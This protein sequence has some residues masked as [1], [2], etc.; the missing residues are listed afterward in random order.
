MDIKYYLDEIYSFKGPNILF[1]GDKKDFYVLSDYFL[2]LLMDD[3]I[4]L[5][6]LNSNLENFKFSKE[7]KKVLLKKDE[8]NC[9]IEFVNN[10]LT[11][12]MSELLIEK[13]FI[14][15]VILS[16]NLSTFYLDFMK[17]DFPNFDTEINIIWTSELDNE[18]N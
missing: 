12:Y 16:R 14:W 8:K 4:K 1:K 17:D 10:T 7:I 9:A 2:K 11:L 5:L 18:S 15:S 3:S 6:V 13:L